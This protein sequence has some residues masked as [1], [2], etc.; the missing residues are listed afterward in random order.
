MQILIVKNEVTPFHPPQITTS[1]S[2]E[3][4]N[5][6]ADKNLTNTGDERNCEDATK[7]YLKLLGVPKS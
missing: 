2:V 5:A 6:V 3:W 4:N 1:F 7:M